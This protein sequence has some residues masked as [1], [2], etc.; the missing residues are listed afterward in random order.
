MKKLYFFVLS[1]LIFNA[2]I[3]AQQA[4]FGVKAGLNV[5]NI[6]NNDPFYDENS[7]YR[8]SFHAG[9]F[10]EIPL[11]SKFS[12]QP[13]LLYSSIGKV[14]R[15]DLNYRIFDL[16]PLG[17]D[18]FKLVQKRNYLTVPL[19]FKWYVAERLYINAGPQVSFLLNTVSKA[20]GDDFPDSYED[21]Y[22]ASGEFKLDYGA[23]LGVGFFIND[24]INIGLQYYRGLKD[25]YADSF[26]DHKAYHSVFQLTAAYSIF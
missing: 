4:R 26:V 13:E 20:K 18:S 8:T 6:D 22:K 12:F 15:Y 21:A 16:E 14:D 24:D 11:N 10:A 9:L 19:T 17:A 5:S 25:L 7:N 1:F 23:V 2:S 3:W